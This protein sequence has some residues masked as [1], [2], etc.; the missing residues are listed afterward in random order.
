MST[1]TTE[2]GADNPSDARSR[3]LGVISLCHGLND[4]MQS[5]I[6][7]S[8]PLLK[9]NH[10]LSFT[11][12]GLLTLTYQC[13]SS[14]LQPL[15]GLYTDRKPQPRSLMAAMAFTLLGLLLLSQAEQF[16]ALLC[17]AA[18]VGM[19]SSIFHPEASRVARMAA[20]GGKAGFA[21]SLFQVG[22]NAGSAL[23]PLLAATVV[24][25]HGQTSLAAFSA[26][27]LLAMALLNHVGAWYASHPRRHA[28]PSA[29]THSHSRRKRV[30]LILGILL[31]LVFSKYFYMASMTSYYTFYLMS[32]FALDVQTA[33]MLLFVFMFAVAL[34]ALL[35]GPLGDRIGRR[36][37][38]WFSI[39]GAAPFTL[40]LPH[41][42]LAGT[43]ALSFGAGMILASAFSSIVVYAQELLPGRVGMVSGLM[44]GFA[45]GVGGVGAGALGQLADHY[46]V[47]VVYQWCAWLPLLGVCAMWLPNLPRTGR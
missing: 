30:A 46:G 16:P 6:L 40:L 5:L 9:Q 39:L 35:G 24:Y 22:G 38:I 11:Q 19:G 20:A 15:V 45:F 23:G 36:R 31:L 21:Q 7:A 3:I 26:V 27:A 1:T 13:T 43:V 33:Q 14:L 44:F 2:L 17:A 47:Q 12:I 32:R 4:M 29:A 34:G 41:A 8:Y 37:V 18:L 42:N 28:G 10:G 25:P